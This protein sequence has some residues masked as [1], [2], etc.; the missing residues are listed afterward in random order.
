M[1]HDSTHADVTQVLQPGTTSWTTYKLSLELPTSGITVG[2]NA[3][4]IGHVVN[5]TRVLICGGQDGYGDTIDT[6]YYLR[7]N[8]TDLQVG[9]GP[10][11]HEKRRGAC[12]VSDG[13]GMAVIGGS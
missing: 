11:L 4:M 1:P 5:N 9:K 8:G 10:S 3:P 6:C 7:R 2:V 13:F 12:T